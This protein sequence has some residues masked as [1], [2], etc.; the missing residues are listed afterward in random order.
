MRQP[1]RR[2]PAGLG[3]PGRSLW[4]SVV[5][6][7]ELAPHEVVI[8]RQACLVADLIER[9]D[10]ELATSPL[11]VAGHAGQPRPSPLLGASAQ[12]RAALKSLLG[13]LGLPMPDELVRR[14]E[15]RTAAAQA[16]WRAQ[17]RKRARDA[18]AA[19]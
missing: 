15:Q 18:Q 8:L 3:A 13:S 12:Q 4:R 2:P 9:V 19:R 11:V 7:Y 17:P 14:D 6:A 5:A 1:P 16:R 10:A